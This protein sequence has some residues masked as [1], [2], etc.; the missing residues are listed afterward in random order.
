MLEC[1]QFMPY[2][3]QANKHDWNDD[4]NADAGQHTERARSDQL[5]LVLTRG[6]LPINHMII[7]HYRV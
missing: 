4:G 2:L 3:L 5:V 1:V 6:K 7:I